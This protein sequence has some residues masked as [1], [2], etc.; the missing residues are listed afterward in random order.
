[1]V[2]LNAR[3]ANAGN[4][5]RTAPRHAN[6]VVK[7]ESVVMGRMFEFVCFSLDVIWIN[8]EIPAQYRQ[9]ASSW[10]ERTCRKMWANQKGTTK[11]RR[12][13]ILC[14]YA[15]NAPARE[16]DRISWPY[17]FTKPSRRYCLSNLLF[18]SQWTMWCMGPNN[19]ASWLW[20]QRSY[21]PYKRLRHSLLQ[22]WV[23]VLMAPNI[24]TTPGHN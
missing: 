6:R 15:T 14:I 9:T 19:R 21:P 2:Q 10:I 11:K 3:V 8:Q 20:P 16:F 18:S 12:S 5:R 24:S 23:R 7:K 13:A 22:D 4:L 1:M 17:I